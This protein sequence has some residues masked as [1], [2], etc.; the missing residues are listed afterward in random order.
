MMAGMDGMGGMGGKAKEP[1]CPEGHNL[2]KR[3]AEAAEYECDVCNKDIPVGKKFHD[4]RKCDW[5]MCGKCH[6]EAAA[7]LE[8]DED[9]EDLLNQ[10]EI[11]EA[12]VEC[13]TTVVRKGK[14]LQH[15]CDICQALFVSED[16]I[17]PHMED[18]HIDVIEEFM[19][20]A[21]VGGGMGMGGF[22]GMGG[23]G[24]GM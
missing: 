2:K 6:K 19:E 7:A 17:L 13:H 9:D 18:K 5:S 23:P 12:F 1:V 15:K 20:E 16:L 14:N 21:M 8:D 22:P 3:K 24:G 11:L 4:C 10:E